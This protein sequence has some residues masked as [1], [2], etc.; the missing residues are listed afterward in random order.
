[1]DLVH[2]EDMAK[3]HILAL[4]NSGADGNSFN[5]GT[6]IPT[7]AVDLASLLVREMCGKEGHLIKFIPHDM[8]GVKL[9]CCN[10]TKARTI[11][12]YSPE[13]NLEK[14]IRSTIEWWKDEANWNRQKGKDG[15]PLGV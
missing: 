2:V 14:G 1:M 7:S 9:R 3:A 4:T 10:I 12:G 15:F 11:L 6:G 13:Y 8:N 5:I